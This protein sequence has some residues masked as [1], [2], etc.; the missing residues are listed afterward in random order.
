MISKTLPLIAGLAVALPAAFTNAAI[1]PAFATNES[2]TFYDS[3]ISATDLIN[4]GTPTLAG[5]TVS[6]NTNIPGGGAAGNDGLNDGIGTN[7]DGLAYWAN[8][9]G[10]LTATY[11][12]TGS[13][14]GYDI[15][16]INT[17]HGWRDSRERHAA[18]RYDV[19][20]ATVLDPGYTLLTSVEYDPYG[21][22]NSNAGQASTQVTLTEDTTGVLASGVTGI[23]FVLFPDPGGNEVGVVREYDVFGTPTIPATAIPSPTAALAGLIGL[24]GLGMRRRRGQ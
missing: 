6:Q 17:I 9:G 8:P 22:V 13:A 5:F 20:I 15:T 7:N 24:A 12:L 23:R 2:Q 18:Q 21:S 16:S 10:S 19:L 11:T 4:V 3:N 14:T 1:I